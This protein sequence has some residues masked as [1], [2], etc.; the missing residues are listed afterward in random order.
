M[1]YENRPTC[2]HLKG[3]AT[4]GKPQP[5]SPEATQQLAL[6]IICVLLAT[7]AGATDYYVAPNGRDSNAGTITEP[8]RTI[9]HAADRVHPG[10]TVHIRAG[11]YYVGQGLYFRRAGMADAPIVYRA[12]D[13]G[14][15]R[16]TNSTVVQGP[17]KKVQGDIYS[18][19]VARGT[20]C[21]FDGDYPLTPPGRHG[22][23][24][25]TIEQMVPGSFLVKD[26]RLYVWLAGGADP[27]ARMIR[28]APYHAISFYDNH[29]N[30]FNGLIVEYTYNAFKRQSDTTHHVTIRNCTIRCIHSQGIQPVAKDCVIEHN[31][32]QKIGT[33][34][35]LHGIYCSTSDTIIRYNIFEEIAGAAIHLYPKGGHTDVYGNVFRKP[36]KM[37]N[38]GYYGEIVAWGDGGHKIYNNVFLGGGVRYGISANSNGNEIYHNTFVGCPR[39]IYLHQGKRGNRVQNNVL[40]EGKIEDQ[41][42][43]S[44]ISNNLKADP[45]FRNAAAGDFRLRPGSPAID[46][47]IRIPVVR[48]DF[49]GTPRPQGNAP[50]LGAFEFVTE[51][52]PTKESNR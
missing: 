19:S 12:D 52:V 13:D 2:L 39:A 46:A 30:V 41:G 6:S 11:D 45:K 20:Q 38:G 17:W 25:D 29:Y 42:V 27:A 26:Q 4:I 22:F 24:G 37:A 8:F 9:Q 21:A 1:K 47:G 43:V 18:A 32:F 36:R 7:V 28:A 50:D 35:F 49:A 48:A 14:P 31:L 51:P 15:V 33:T 10:D 40:V 44:V 3:I 5:L 23:K 16:I 34:K